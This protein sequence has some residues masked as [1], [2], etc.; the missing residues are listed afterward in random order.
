MSG[1]TFKFSSCLITGATDGIG[2]ITAKLIAQNC[3][4]FFS[5][6]SLPTSSQPFILGIHGRCPDRLERTLRACQTLVPPHCAD[7]VAILTFCYDLSDL[8]KVHRF[9]D[10]VIEQFST[11]PTE[12][13][14]GIVYAASCHDY[15]F[16]LD[17]L[18]NNAAIFDENGPHTS[19]SNPKLELTFAVNVLAPFVLTQRL[20]TRALQCRSTIKK[21]INT[22]STSHMDCQ[23]HLRRLDYENL[24]F[25][26]TKWTSFSSYGL[27]KLLVNMFTRAFYFNEHYWHTHTPQGIE[28]KCQRANTCLIN[29][30]PGTVNTKMLLAGWGACGIPIHEATDTYEL[31]AGQRFYKPDEVPKYY[32]GLR[33]TIP[34]PQTN[35]Q[36]DCIRLYHYLANLATGL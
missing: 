7:K 33:E 22:S 6:D 9:C 35:S 25:E 10:D 2:L 17:V 34:T 1:A 20:L 4:Q 27:S 30:D 31:I 3:E 14:T 28:G 36:D 13:S 19:P 12:P 15:R 11:A 18:V 5:E 26:K 16:Q 8:P 21:V 32:V 24:Q 29:M 23:H